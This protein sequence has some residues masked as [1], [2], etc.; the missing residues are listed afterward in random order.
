MERL[1]R[2][3]RPVEHRH[4]RRLSGAHH[5]DRTTS[6]FGSCSDSPTLDP[7]TTYALRLAK[8]NGTSRSVVPTTL[9]DAS[10]LHLSL[11]RVPIGA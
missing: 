2:L 11:W 4:S 1:R 3:P 8:P 5:G 7:M 6:G 10:W 9:R